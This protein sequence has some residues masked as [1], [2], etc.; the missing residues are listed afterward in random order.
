MVGNKFNQEVEIKLRVKDVSAL[1]RR[2]KH[3]SAKQVSPRTHEFNTLYD[4]PKKDLARRGKL[5]RIRTEQPGPQPSQK[6]H[7]PAILTYKGPPQTQRSARPAIDSPRNKRRY[8]IREEA[9]VTVSDEAQTRRILSAL[10]LRPV[11]RYEKFRTT[12][13]HPGVRNLKIELDETPIGTFMELEGSPSAIDRVSRLLGFSPSDYITQSYGAL[14]IAAR[15][16][17]KNKP[18]N[19]LFTP[20]KNLP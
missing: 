17:G 5:I 11:F 6:N 19:M 8:K 10:G 13:V 18:A 16:L 1:R 3:L 15:R 9:E 2:L 14:F 4:T 12:Y 20:T 7:Q